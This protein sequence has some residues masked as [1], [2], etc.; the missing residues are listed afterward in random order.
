[1][2]H[3]LKKKFATLSTFKTFKNEMGEKNGKSSQGFWIKQQW[4]VH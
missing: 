3:F 1:M 4:K 2:G